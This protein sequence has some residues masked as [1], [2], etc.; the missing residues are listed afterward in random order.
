MKTDQYIA[1]I[2]RANPNLFR[3][4]SAKISLSSVALE[5]SLRA[6]YEAGF[7]DADKFH[8]GVQTITGGKDL[9]GKLFR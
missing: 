3:T 6:A 2:R 8:K 1:R 9:F 7:Q 4:D 5:R